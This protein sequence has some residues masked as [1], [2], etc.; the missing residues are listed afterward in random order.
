M[1]TFKVTAK[2]RDNSGIIEER[3][4]KTEAKRCDYFIA[5][6]IISKAKEIQLWAIGENGYWHIIREF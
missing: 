5:E 6:L 3:F 4:K 1:F 2:T